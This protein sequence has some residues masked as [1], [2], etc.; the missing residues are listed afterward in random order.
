MVGLLRLF[1]RHQSTLTLLILYRFDLFHFF[2]IFNTTPIIK[3]IKNA[4]VSTLLTIVIELASEILTSDT[5]GVRGKN[6]NN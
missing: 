4:V 2:F 6:V 1:K 3:S 5:F